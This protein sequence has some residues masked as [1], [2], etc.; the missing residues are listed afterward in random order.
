M[1]RDAAEILKDA[2]ELPTEARAA[3]AGLLMESLDAEVNE[4]AEAAWATEV[5]RQLQG[6]R[7]ATPSLVHGVAFTTS[8]LR[9]EKDAAIHARVEIR[10]RT[11][12]L[13]PRCVPRV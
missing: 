13:V 11:L 8:T 1:K 4:D 9:Q 10:Q 6:Q 2:L 5:S 7:D 3:V 12:A